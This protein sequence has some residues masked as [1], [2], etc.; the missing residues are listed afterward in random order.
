MQVRAHQFT[1]DMSM[2]QPTRVLLAA[3]CLA[4]LP[5]LA[6]AQGVASA[7]AM[8]NTP[9]TVAPSA[10]EA[11][12]VAQPGVAVAPQTADADVAK[13][14]S[15]PAD[16]ASDDASADASGS[17][18]DNVSDAAVEPQSVAGPSLAAATVGVRSHTAREDLTAQQSAQRAAHHGGLGTD[19]ALM[20]V[21]GAAFI[22]GLIIGGGAGTAI[23]IAGAAV[24]LYGLYLYLQ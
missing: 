17:D 20:I 22:A 2:H 5:G 13:R 8:G 14:A 16:G 10:G 11:G 12:P 4:T 15:D 21:G 7:D 23:A 1:E 3:V 19:G 24:G 18:A 6:A 9:T